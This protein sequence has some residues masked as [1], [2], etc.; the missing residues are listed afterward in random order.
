MAEQFHQWVQ[1]LSWY[2]RLYYELFDPQQI[3]CT[4]RFTFPFGYVLIIFLIIT[5]ILVIREWRH[6]NGKV[7]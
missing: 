2:D 7:R 5:I 1:N 6:K 3:T 4:T